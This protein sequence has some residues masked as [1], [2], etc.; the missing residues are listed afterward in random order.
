MMTKGLISIYGSIILFAAIHFILS[1]TGQTERAMMATFIGG[2]A[3]ILMAWAIWLSTRPK[4]LE[5][6]F[7][8]LDKIYV[9]HKFIGVSILLLILVHF[10]AIPKLETAQRLPPVGLA[11]ITGWLATPFGMISMILIILSIVISLNRKIPY[12]IWIKPHKLMGLLYIAVFIHMLLS[13]IELFNG[14]SAS[15]M[16]LFLVGLFG[17]GAYIYR[18]FTR[19]KRMQDYKLTAINQ[20]ERATELV[21]TP[22]SGQNVTFKPGQFGFIS[23]DQAGFN[24]PHPFTIS[25]APH[26]NNL[27]FT[28]KVLGD[29]TRR[30]RDQLKLGAN[31]KIEGPY[32]RFNMQIANKHQIWIAGG[33]GITPFL[34]AMRDMQIEDNRNITLFYCLQ[35]KNQALFLDEFEAKFTNSPNRQLIILQSNHKQFATIDVIKKQVGDDLS[36]FDIFLCGPKPMVNG[37]K[38]SFKKAKI[39]SSKI[40]SEAFEFR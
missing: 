38:K 20:L 7:G 22:T 28:I 14:K 17:S 31:A 32:G 29:F 19:N 10:F 23:L 6:W 8:G 39:A 16:L 24:E 2:S 27:R 9:A 3:M 13:P 4:W 25:S 40:H 5:D 11:A 34:S 35:E 36:G 26:E 15:G 21:L 1:G 12:H 18:Q 30:I 37:L 33:V